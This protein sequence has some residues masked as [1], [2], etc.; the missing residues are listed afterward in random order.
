M[1]QATTIQ[2]TWAPRNTN[3]KTSVVGVGKLNPAQ[4]VLSD[5][6]E[7]ALLEVAK[8][9]LRSAAVALGDYDV[10]V[11]KI[12][13]HIDALKGLIISGMQHDETPTSF[14]DAARIRTRLDGRA[15]FPLRS[16]P[17]PQRTI[18]TDAEQKD[19]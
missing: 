3:V 2:E 7:V 5:S 4:Q 10:K 15:N 18:S 16:A 19:N 12:N 6:P 8:M 1:D 11:D 13:E 14:E 17:A 9:S